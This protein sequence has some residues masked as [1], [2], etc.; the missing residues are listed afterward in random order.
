MSVV[1]DCE[2][3]FT[4]AWVAAAAATGSLDAAAA[5][6]EEVDPTELR[7]AEQEE[8][9]EKRSVEGRGVW[10]AAEGFA[11]AVRRELGAMEGATIRAARRGEGYSFVEGEEGDRGSA[12]RQSRPVGTWEESGLGHTGG[13]N[14]FFWASMGPADSGWALLGQ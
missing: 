4:V 10:M 1:W 14:G 13:Q 2:G 5:V 8:E 3:W 6:D 11:M 7:V 12:T 9:D